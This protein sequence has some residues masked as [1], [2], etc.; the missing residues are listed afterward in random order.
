MQRGEASLV[1]PHVTRGDDSPTTDS[2]PQLA[3]DERSLSRLWILD[4]ATKMD[5]RFL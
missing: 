2:G 5:H 1:I 3:D 4:V